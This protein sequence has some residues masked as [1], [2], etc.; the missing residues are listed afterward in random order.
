M[1]FATDAIHRHCTAQATI[2][3][4]LGPLTLARTRLGLAG[5]WFEGQQHHPGPL[6]APHDE[7]DPLLAQVAHELRA[8]FSGRP[9][10]FDLALDL[11]GTPFQQRVWR[12]LLGIAAGGTSSYARIAAACDAPRAVRAVGAAIGRN[13]VSIIVP[14]HRVIGSDG[15]LTGYAGGI[16]RKQAL[17]DLESQRRDTK[18]PA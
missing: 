11:H 4:P 17:L 14:C 5:A 8:Y 13:P 15:T 1:T 7:G 3:T 10:R 2:D 6:A 12:A 18:A 9:D 16:A